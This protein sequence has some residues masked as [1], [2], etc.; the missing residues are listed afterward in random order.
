MDGKRFYAEVGDVVSISGGR[1]ARL[2]Q[3]HRQAGAPV[4]PD[5]AGARRRGVLHRTGRG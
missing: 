4:H 5:R 1:R 2:R 3:R